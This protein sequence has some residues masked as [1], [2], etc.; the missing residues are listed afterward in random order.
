MILT[1]YI[2]GF[3]YAA[4]C[5]LIAAVAYKLG[6]AKKFTRKIV[7]I[8][9]GFEWI[10]LYRFIGSGIHF[11]IVC[12]FFLA[13]LT[14]SYKA[15]IM[16]MISS[17]D[18]N[19]PGTVYYAAAMTGVALIGCFVPQLMLPFGIGVFCTSLGDGLAGVVGQIPFKYNPVVYGK[20]T[21][22]GTLTN[23]VISTAS[24]F[25]LS[26]AYGMGLSL[27]HCV[28]I[29]FLAM[30]LELVSEGGIDN[31]TITWG[32]TAL[33]YGFMHFPAMT[34]Y[35]I[36][37]LATVPIIVLVKM[38][39]ALTKSGLIVA[40]VL[41]IIVSVAFG[42]FGFVT[43]SI[44][45][46]GAMIVDKIKKRV[47]KSSRNDIEAKGDCRDHMQVLANGLAAAVVSIGY[48]ISGKSI[49]IIAFV[50]AVAEAFADTCASGIGV[51]AER[52]FDPF[53]MKKCEKGL[54]GGMS[55]V[56]TL[57]S[58]LA[59]ALIAFSVILWGISGYG[60]REVLIVTVAGFFGAV[61]DSFLGSVFQ[62]KY[63]CSVCDKLTERE[64]HCSKP[65][66][67]I[68]GFASI[69]NDIVNLISS[70]IAPLIAVVLTLIF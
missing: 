36:P 38:K 27:W 52:T 47:K 37:V 26:F 62:A 39:K 46:V 2:T 9:V 50:A 22:F 44:F 48:L 17:D 25:L 6:L 31:V 63:R 49:L 23:F 51:F 20:K 18:D 64:E 30:E 60:V 12:I 8:L 65:T 69:D 68:S 21:L 32:T 59:S 43:L 33:A 55:F 13:L 58:L 54:S 4:I 57:A 1:G 15:K 10:L 14:I 29:G 42:N 41:D 24:S 40:F 53:R 5:L 61:F 35:L 45:F 19:S 56:G 3:L 16:D 67:R 66:I 70:A 7:H 11:L 34:D 28:A